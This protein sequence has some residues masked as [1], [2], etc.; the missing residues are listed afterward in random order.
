MLC[1]NRLKSEGNN[2]SEYN[3]KASAADI[4]DLRNVLGIRQFNLLSVSYSTKIAQVL[5][6]DYPVS[7]RSAVLDS[8]LPLWV[9]Y[10]ET[11]NR[12]FTEKLD[13][14]FANC[15]LD[16]SCSAAFP[17]LKYRFL[18]FLKSAEKEP[19]TVLLKSPIDSTLLT[20]KV[21]GGQIASF[22][23][24][25][26]TW[27]LAGLPK[28]MD[29]L[30]RGNYQLITPF[31]Y[32]LMHPG[33]NAMGMRLSVWCSEEYPFENNTAAKRNDHSASV[34]ANRKSTAVPLAICPIWKVTR[35][36]AR[37]NQPFKTNVPVL[38]LNGEY[39]P[40]TPPSW[41]SDINRRFPKSFHFVFTGMGHTPTQYWDN[42]CG[43]QMANAF[44]NQP[45]QKPELPCFLSLPK[46][47]FDTKK[48]D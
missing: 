1:Q 37:E 40:D 9:N 46:L 39:D 44:F 35:A 29:G 21:S 28:L 23:D 42:A 45:N 38:I 2:L 36:P 19:V 12:H 20:V 14:L 27:G 26:N 33:S 7:I 3:T 32:A 47:K 13:L 4:E 5:L 8:P 43:M 41:G 31:L 6:R 15:A 22:L 25:G 24:F 34:F 48:P 30:C 18:S 10:D 17:N 11:S 16:S